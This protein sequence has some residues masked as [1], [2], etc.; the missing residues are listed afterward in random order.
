ML[1]IDPWEEEEK[2]VDEEEED[3]N[4]VVIIVL[5]TCGSLA[6]SSIKLFFASS[7]AK[8]LCNVGCCYHFLAEEF[9]RN[10]FAEETDDPGTPGGGHH[11]VKK[12]NST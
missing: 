7:S 10:P 9:Y 1:N 6:A 11:G 4:R 2:D 5:H 12:V 3:D 8:F